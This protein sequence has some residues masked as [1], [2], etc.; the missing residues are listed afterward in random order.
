MLNGEKGREWK[1]ANLPISRAEVMPTLKTGKFVFAGYD[2]VGRA[3]C[4]YRV[5]LHD[6][7]KFTALESVRAVV[8]NYEQILAEGKLRGAGEIC[9]VVDRTDAKSSNM[10]IEVR[11]AFWEGGREGGSAGRGEKI[12]VV[13]SYL[14]RLALAQ[15]LNFTSF[16]STPPPMTQFMKLLY[17]MLKESYPARG[18]LFLVLG[19][20]FIFRKIWENLVSV[21]LDAKSRSATHLLKDKADLLDF[22]EE[23]QLVDWLGGKLPYTFVPPAEE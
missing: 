23:E 15:I 9:V 21:F 4:Y 7:K 17:T 14:P 5:K 16:P 8:Y 20:N 13:L 2:K 19:V 22:I 1:K 11:E 6:P 3:V 12:K 18:E 10:D